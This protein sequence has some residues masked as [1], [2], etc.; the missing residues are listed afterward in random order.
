MSLDPG[1]TQTIRNFHLF[2]I[3]IQNIFATCHTVLSVLYFLSVS[4]FSI[5]TKHP[6]TLS[7]E[8]TAANEIF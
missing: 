1:I 6:L 8:M 7:S 5:A 2:L 4:H 3:V